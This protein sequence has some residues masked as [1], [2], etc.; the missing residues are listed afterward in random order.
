MR[1]GDQV[2]YKGVKMW[3]I[4]VCADI[5]EVAPTKHGAGSIMT[6]RQYLQ[7]VV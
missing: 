2:L 7:E 3:L 4:S 6:T 5:Y 1:I